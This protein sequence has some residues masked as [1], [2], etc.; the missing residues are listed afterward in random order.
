[1]SSEVISY[2]VS[3]NKNIFKKEPI[4]I[5]LPNFPTPTGPSLTKSFYPN[6]VNI[7]KASEKLLS[8]KV[9]IPKR[10]LDEIKIHDIPYT[11]YTGPF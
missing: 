2:L 3:Y 4:K 5:S 11:N 6:F 1:M 10:N 8:K 9:V 7:I